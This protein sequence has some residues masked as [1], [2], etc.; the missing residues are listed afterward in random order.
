MLFE[1][2]LARHAGLP[3]G[4]ALTPDESP[5]SPIV[6]RGLAA[7]AVV[8]V[9]TAL[10]GLLFGAGVALGVLAVGSAAIIAFHVWN[11]DRLARWAA[12]FEQVPAL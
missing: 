6:L 2:D 4:G 12:Q 1:G 10:A 11:L 5:M 7:P 3:L 9:L 8:I